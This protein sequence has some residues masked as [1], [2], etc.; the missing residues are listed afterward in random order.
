MMLK[1]T[2][3]TITY[4]AAK[5]LQRT[6]DSVMQQT[7]RD[8]EHLIVD[9]ASKDDT[10][11]LAR[12]YQQQSD[13]S[14]N[15][16]SVVITSEPDRGIYDAMN[17]GLRQATGDYIVFMNAGDTFH[18]HDTLAR[19]AQLCEAADELPA[20]VYGDTHIVD[21]EGRFLYRRRLTPPERLSWRSF[22][23]GMLVCHQA[24]Y[25]RRDVAQK[26]PYDLRYRFSADVDWCIRV[27][28]EA[29]EK[30]L[31]LINSHEVVADYLEEG[32]TTQHH[33]ASLRERFDV[34][35]RHYGLPTTL[36]MH[37]WFIVRA[38]IRRR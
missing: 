6:L 5:V 23:S 16:H 24:F 22:R 1:I 34:M 37:A 12:R 19:I 2:V 20:V 30:K 29:A 7:H 4:N 25:A 14:G 31:Q 3:V 13:S 36:L 21:G 9:G 11:D 15:G 32:A 27:M 35:R 28:K 8:V 18:A 33:R 10:V 17:K 38:A 26:T